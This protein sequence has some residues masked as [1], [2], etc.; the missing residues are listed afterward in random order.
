MKDEIYEFLTFKK[1]N[2]TNKFADKEWLAI[3]ANLVN[4]FQYLNSINKSLQGKEMSFHDSSEKMKAFLMKIDL[5]TEKVCNGNFA[6]FPNFNSF[7]D[8]NEMIINQEI[9]DGIKEQLRNLQCKLL[10]YF[11]QL[12][13]KSR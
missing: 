13:S 10:V 1:H 9:S 2:L 4:I 5:W 12:G 8:E 7:I 11:P 6:M 3:V